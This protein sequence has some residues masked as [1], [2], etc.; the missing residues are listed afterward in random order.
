LDQA[1]IHVLATGGPGKGPIFLQ[2]PV[3]LVGDPVG[4]V[5]LEAPEAASVVGPVGKPLV[6]ATSAKA[7]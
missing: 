5:G 6:P 1:V 7:C 3:A 2:P 4:V